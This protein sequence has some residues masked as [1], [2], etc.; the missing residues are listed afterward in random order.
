M[1]NDV[2]ANGREI[3]C[4]AADGKSIAAFPDVC[5]SPPTPP[6]GPVPLPYPNTAY[7]SD[8]AGGSKRVRISGKEVMLRDSSYFKKSTGDEAATKTLPRG[9]VTHALQGKAYFNSWSMDVKIEGQNAVRHL[10]LT[11]HNHMSKPG[12][13]PP[14]PYAD[15]AAVPEAPA[16]E[17]QCKCCGEAAHSEAQRQGQEISESEFYSTPDGQ[18]WLELVRRGPSGAPGKCSHLAPPKAKPVDP[19]SRYF[20]NTPAENRAARQRFGEAGANPLSNPNSLPHVHG[21]GR[22]AHKVPLCAGGCP[23]GERN[24]GA[25]R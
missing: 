12:Q 23:S 3:S 10:D 18:A 17:E 4:K 14:W 8:T 11:T 25:R 24:F 2:F 16:T 6:A 5:L 21:R 15:A 19:C 22:L 20:R 7:A 13:T 9:F 1:A